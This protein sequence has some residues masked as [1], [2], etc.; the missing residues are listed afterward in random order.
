MPDSFGLSFIK[1]NEIPKGKMYAWLPQ[2]IAYVPWRSL[3]QKMGED[4][5]YRFHPKF[6]AEEAQGFA[7]V[8]DWGVVDITI[9]SAA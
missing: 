1:C 8:D 3:T 5:T 6:Y 4:A 2:A 9:K 7:R